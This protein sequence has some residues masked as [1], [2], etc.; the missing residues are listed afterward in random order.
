MRTKSV[1]EVDRLNEIFADDLK[2][3]DCEIMRKNPKKR[4]REPEALRMYTKKKAREQAELEAK[5][6]NPFI[7]GE[8]RVEKERQKLQS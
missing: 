5:D 4:M 7:V 1:T 8:E 2:I 3:L 6:Y